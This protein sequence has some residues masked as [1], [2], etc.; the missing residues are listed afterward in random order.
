M[1]LVRAEVNALSRQHRYVF[2]FLQ[3]GS[4]NNILALK[5]CSRGDLWIR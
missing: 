1:H 5:T 2:K 3:Q 4:L